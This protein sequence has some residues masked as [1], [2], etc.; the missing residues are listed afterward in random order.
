MAT[1]SLI[2]SV[3]QVPQRPDTRSR[4]V[5]ARELLA[6]RASREGKPNDQHL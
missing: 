5:G 3:A 2:D 4:Q 6:R 1:K